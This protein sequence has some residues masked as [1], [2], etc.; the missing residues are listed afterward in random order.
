MLRLYGYNKMQLLKIESLWSCQVDM[1]YTAALE[2]QDMKLQDTNLLTLKL[3][4][5]NRSCGIR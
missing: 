5:K 1:N 3:N 4:A 2:L